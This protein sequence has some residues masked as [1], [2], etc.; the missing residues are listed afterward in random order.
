MVLTGKPVGRVGR[1]QGHVFFISTSTLSFPPRGLLSLASFCQRCEA[2]FNPRGVLGA[3]GNP[4][5]PCWGFFHIQAPP[6]RH[7]PPSI[8]VQYP[9]AFLCNARGV[10]RGVLGEGGNPSCSCPRHGPVP[11]CNTVTETEPPEYVCSI[12]GA[13]VSRECYSPPR[14][15]ESIL[16]LHVAPLLGVFPYPG[17]CT[18][19]RLA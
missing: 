6:L 10:L 1:C 8:S 2:F 19:G 3:G 11:R 13:L 18:E 12:R 15:R 16:P 9:R 5:P 7:S 4:I 14:R 17:G